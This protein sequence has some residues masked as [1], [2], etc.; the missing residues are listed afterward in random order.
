MHNTTLDQYWKYDAVILSLL[1]IFLGF[2]KTRFCNSGT[3]SILWNSLA[4]T[5]KH[6]HQMLICEP[7]R[8]QIVH[9]PPE[10][11]C[12]ALNQRHHK[13]SMKRKMFSALLF[14]VIR[15]QSCPSDANDT[16]CAEFNLSDLQATNDLNDLCSQMPSMPSCSLSK[17]CTNNLPQCKPFN[18]LGAA[19]VDIPMM[20]GC[21]SF[22][23]MCGDNPKSSAN[24][25][26]KS[27]NIGLIPTSAQTTQNIY[28]ICSSMKMDGCQNCQ[29]D[30][31]T[32]T[33][34]N[35]DLLQTYSFLCK[36]MPGMLQCKDYVRM[37][38]QA[39]FSPYCSPNIKSSGILDA[40][41]PM[42]MFFHT[43]IN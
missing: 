18:K 37:C 26:C 31:P 8:G 4:D 6:G 22:I 39:P 42:K 41:P 33:Y 35:C 38:Q 23:K 20:T 43:G 17:T 24:S 32:A 40:I 30:S 11:C 27:S 10:S 21:N 36:S 5:Q 16:A 28:A 3:K 15:A 7:P 2:L 19:C 29:I 9:V 14:S 25:Q 34:A 1:D 13:F 12:M